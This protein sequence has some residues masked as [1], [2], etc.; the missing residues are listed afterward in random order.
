MSGA[1]I[2]MREREALCDLMAELGPDAPT[3]CE[4]WDT[5]DLAAHL[6]LRE[7][8]TRGTDEHM[9]AERA[10]GLPALIERLRGGP[11]PVPWRLPGLR[12]L[13]NGLEYFIHHED[14]RRAN[15]LARR[16]DR[17]DLDALAWRMCG[18]AGRRAARQIRPH[19]LELRPPGGDPRRFGPPGGAVLQG[20]PTELLLYLSGRR[21]AAQVRLTGD[22]DA[23][24]ALRGADTAV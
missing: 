20:E 12:T 21:D 14:V 9:A 11:P 15:G 4:G 1:P 22:A 5:I 24:A 16:T 19:S 2:D 17:P 6:V 18:F 10:K 3:L 23:V 13:M 7:H 8:F